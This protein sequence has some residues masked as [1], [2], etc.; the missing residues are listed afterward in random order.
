MITLENMHQK[1]DRQHPG[2]K[3]WELPPPVPFF[4]MLSISSFRQKYWS[5][6]LAHSDLLV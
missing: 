2:L 4:N 5:F 1:L 6:S 3:Q